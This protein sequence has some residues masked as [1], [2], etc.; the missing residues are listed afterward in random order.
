MCRLDGAG[1]FAL[2][3]IGIEGKAAVA[4]LT[5]ALKDEDENVRTIAAQW[6][7]KIDAR[8]AKKAGVK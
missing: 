8:A 3:R 6:L 1:V 2:G 7:K 5:D 4:A